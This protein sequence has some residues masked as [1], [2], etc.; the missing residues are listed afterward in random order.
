M[1]A[2][3]YTFSALLRHFDKKNINELLYWLLYPISLV[4]Y[5]VTLT[6]KTLRSYL[7]GCYI[8]PI[9]LSSALLRHFDK[10]NVKKLLYWLDCGTLHYEHDSTEQASKNQEAKEKW[11]GEELLP[12]TK[13][14]LL[15][16]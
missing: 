3:S 12:T 8:Q 11:P 2:C 9:N 5:Y 7:T 13:N 10:K 16:N 6:R 1:A 14:T 15:Q 4:P